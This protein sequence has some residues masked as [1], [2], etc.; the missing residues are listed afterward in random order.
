MAETTYGT[1]DPIAGALKTRKLAVYS[2]TYYLGMPLKWFITGSAANTGTGNSVI[3]AIKANRTMKPGAYR[4]TFSAATVG[5]LKDPDG[6]ILLNE[7]TLVTTVPV[8]V[9]GL[10]FTWT[11]G[12]TPQI[13]GDYIVITIGATGYYEYNIT[14]PEVIAWEDKVVSGASTLVCA[15]TGSEILESGLVDDTNTLL[16]MTEYI[17][18]SMRDNGIILR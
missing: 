12:A 4:F 11:V 17:R 10:S 1:S 9:A 3:S 13:N 2:D 7:V 16:T 8:K 14:E 18:V 5:T 15:V 6:N